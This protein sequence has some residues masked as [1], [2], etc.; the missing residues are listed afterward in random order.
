MAT[1]L[2]AVLVFR[3]GVSKA[4]A[5]AALACIQKFLEPSYSFQPSS[6]Y[7]QT[8]VPAVREYDDD[9]GGPVWYIP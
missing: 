1:R 8:P 7:V 4:D 6:G 2:G 3:E 9:I 5:E